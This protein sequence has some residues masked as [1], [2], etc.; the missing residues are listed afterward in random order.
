MVFGEYSTANAPENGHAL[1]AADGL[2]VLINNLPHKVNI[3]GDMG[4]GDHRRR[5]LRI[6][7]EFHKVPVLFNAPQG[8]VICVCQDHRPD[9]QIT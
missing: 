7:M 3:L 6:V 2:K 5:L 9:P 8:I 1:C 4:L